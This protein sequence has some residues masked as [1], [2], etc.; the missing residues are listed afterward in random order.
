M[1]FGSSV[2]TEPTGLDKFVDE[3][4]PTVVST[5]RGTHHDLGVALPSQSQSGPR[6]CE[7]E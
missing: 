5:H 3:V 6:G 2:G 4:E 1:P 7:E